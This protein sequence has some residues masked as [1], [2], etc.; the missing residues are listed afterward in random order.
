MSWVKVIGAAIGRKVF[1]NG[2]HVDAAGFVGTPF[3]V[4]P[5]LDTFELLTPSG[6]VEQS[7][8]AVISGHPSKQNPQIVNIGSGSA[9]TTG[10][11]SGRS[12]P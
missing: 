5:G 8:S 11:M 7:T 9:G 6:S 3:E 2:N 4:D 1:V 10:A 12:A